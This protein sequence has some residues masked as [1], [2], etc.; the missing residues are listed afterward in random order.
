MDGLAL[1]VI[2]ILFICIALASI[3]NR[4]QVS[5]PPLL[6]Q[7]VIHTPHP[8]R[9]AVN[10]HYSGYGSVP[11]QPAVR[12]AIPTVALPTSPLLSTPLSP[13]L[14]FEPPR[15]Q[16]TRV[17]SGTVGQNQFRENLP[18]ERQRQLDVLRTGQDAEAACPWKPIRQG[19]AQPTTYANAARVV[20]AKTRAQTVAAKNMRGQN[21]VQG[22]AMPQRKSEAV[23][24]Q[25]LHKNIVVVQ[26]TN[27]GT[28]KGRKKRRRREVPAGPAQV[29]W[30]SHRLRRGFS[31]HPFTDP[32]CLE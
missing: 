24:D 28:P 7:Y 30:P 19:Q 9:S 2:L 16:S 4:Q 21:H 1:W 32:E 23:P 14:L 20:R 3:D 8:Q 5:P 27:V 6:P 11:A 18:A 17:S 26:E 22:E 10:A 29:R 31:P 25:E 15:Y 13:P 12:P